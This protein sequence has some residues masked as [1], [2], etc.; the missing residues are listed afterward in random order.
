MN[1]W[2]LRRKIWRL[3]GMCWCQKEELYISRQ[4][5]WLTY[6]DNGL[7]RLERFQLWIICKGKP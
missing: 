1:I 4:Y 5:N 2:Y 6:I 7:A 3:Q